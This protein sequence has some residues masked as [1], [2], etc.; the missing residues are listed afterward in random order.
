MVYHMGSS[1]QVAIA[2]IIIIITHDTSW[3]FDKKGTNQ[4]K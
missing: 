1:Q 4:M 3:K 2:I